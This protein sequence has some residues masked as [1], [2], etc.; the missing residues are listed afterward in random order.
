[1]MSI[2]FLLSSGGGLL[3]L[4]WLSLSGWGVGGSMGWSSVFGAR[5]SS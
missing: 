5:G 1:M 2:G 4:W 3:S